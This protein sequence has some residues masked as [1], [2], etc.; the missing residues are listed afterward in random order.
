[1]FVLEGVPCLRRGLLNFL[2]RDPIHIWRPVLFYGAAA[3]CL[4]IVYGQASA[5]LPLQLFPLEIQVMGY[6]VIPIWSSGHYWSD[7]LD[8]I[9]RSRRW[10]GGSFCL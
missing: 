8:K 5:F 6:T 2:F 4:W 3:Q 7:R 10:E 9:L 1:M